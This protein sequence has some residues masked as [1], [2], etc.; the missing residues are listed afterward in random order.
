MTFFCFFAAIWKYFTTNR[1]RCYNKSHYIW[2]RNKRG[3]YWVTI[4]TNPPMPFITVYTPSWQ[5]TDSKI[6]TIL[7]AAT[8]TNIDTP[9][10]VVIYIRVLSVVLIIFYNI[11][12][13]IIYIFQ[14]LNHAYPVNKRPKY[15]YNIIIYTK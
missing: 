8:E 6:S 2:T 1:N 13:R 15:N 11:I 14:I 7:F 4:C 9:I 5:A 12:C 3:R 10:T